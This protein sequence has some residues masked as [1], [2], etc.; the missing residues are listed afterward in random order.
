MSLLRTTLV[1][2]ALVG[3]GYG[4]QFSPAM[5]EGK[6][7]AEAAWSMYK[8]AKVGRSALVYAAD[9]DDHLPFA[10][11][12]YAFSVSYPLRGD[13][14]EIDPEM[15]V[16]CRPAN[17]ALQGYGVDYATF[18]SP[19]DDRPEAETDGKARTWFEFTAT[20]VSQGSSY[21]YWWARSLTD[22][23]TNEIK[24]AGKT[25]MFVSMFPVPGDEG[26]EYQVV[27]ASGEIGTMT[28]RELEPTPAPP[29]E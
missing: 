23:P 8:L 12:N 22:Q 2:C 10:P 17:V 29:S 9:Q 14:T 28:R 3:A 4:A 21:E 19:A 18:R 15:G 27:F 11:G 6:K 7:R 26:E 16:G 5:K 24:G 25:P 1:A 20:E 13:C